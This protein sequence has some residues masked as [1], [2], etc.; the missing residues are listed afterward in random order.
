MAL[1]LQLVLLEP[2][3]VELLARGA[4]LELPRDVFLVVADDSGRE[5]GKGVLVWVGVV[6]WEL[7]VVGKGERGK[8]E[9]KG[10]WWV[11]GLVGW[12]G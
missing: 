5:G 11:G 12:L 9:R 4:A 2:A 7:R 10:V 8:E 6:G 3:D 1:E